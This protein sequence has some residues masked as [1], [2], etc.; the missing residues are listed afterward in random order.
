MVLGAPFLPIAGVAAEALAPA[1]AW[2]ALAAATDAIAATVP[3]RV[4]A[5]TSAVRA[6]VA[7]ARA[8]LNTMYEATL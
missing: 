5:A 8:S 6:V 2:F 3:F 4:L 1:A 7:A